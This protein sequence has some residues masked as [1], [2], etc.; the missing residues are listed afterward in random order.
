[1]KGPPDQEPAAEDLPLVVR[2]ASRMV[3]SPSEAKDYEACLLKVYNEKL[4]RLGSRTARR[5]LVKET[6]CLCGPGAIRAIKALIVAYFL[7]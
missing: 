7:R 5:Y 6:L 3:Y 4:S 2:I 1:M